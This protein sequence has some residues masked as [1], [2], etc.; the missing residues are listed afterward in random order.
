MAWTREQEDRL[1]DC[2]GE[3]KSASECAA[4]INEA[5]LSTKLVTRDMVIGKARRM[6]LEARPSPIKREAAE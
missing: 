6:G 1:R 5:G 2:W 4:A 3:G